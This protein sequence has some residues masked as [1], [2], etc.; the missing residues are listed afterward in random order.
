MSNSRKSKSGN[1]KRVKVEEV[2]E[3]ETV[4]RRGRIRLTLQPVK[5]DQLTRKKTATNKKPVTRKSLSP[6][7]CGSSDPVKKS[8]GSKVCDKFTYKMFYGSY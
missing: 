6:V 8:S 7:A 2:E 3:V 4:D 5:H 1:K